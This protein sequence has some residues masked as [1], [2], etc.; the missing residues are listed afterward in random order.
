MVAQRLYVSLLSERWI[1]FYLACPHHIQWLWSD[2][3][4]RSAGVVLALPGVE[5]KLLCPSCSS[6]YTK[7]AVSTLVTSLSAISLVALSRLFPYISPTIPELFLIL[8]ASCCSQNIPGIISTGLYTGS[9]R[10]EFLQLRHTC[11]WLCRQQEM[12]RQEAFLVE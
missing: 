3:D 7:S 5:L 6:L 11:T 8:S 4:G 12:F 10:A 9:T 2:Q 1:T